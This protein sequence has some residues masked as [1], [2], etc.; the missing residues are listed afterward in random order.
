MPRGKPGG[1]PGGADITLHRQGRGRLRRHG[2]IEGRRRRSGHSG[3]DRGRA[4]IGAGVR[5]TGRCRTPL[6]FFCGPGNEAQV[7]RLFLQS[8]LAER[9]K[10][11]G[12]PDYLP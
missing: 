10:V 1:E 9:D 7:E 5:P 6:A 8:K 11:T 3:A 12:R 2:P 4:C